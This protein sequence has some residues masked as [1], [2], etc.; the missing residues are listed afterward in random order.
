MSASRA[1]SEPPNQIR[2]IKPLPKI[3]L[4][5]P[6]PEGD[7]APPHDAGPLR[8]QSQPP[9]DGGSTQRGST[10]PAPA[11][12]R[13]TVPTFTQD[14]APP[15]SSSDRSMVAQTQRTFA[16]R[17]ST[18]TTPL[19]RTDSIHS[20]TEPAPSDLEVYTQAGLKWPPKGE[21]AKERDERTEANFL[22]V[23]ML[24]LAQQKAV[25]NLHAT[26]DANYAEILHRLEDMQHGGAVLGSDSGL[27]DIV[28]ENRGAIENLT[29][30]VN[31]LQDTQTEFY[32]FRRE[33]RNDIA[34]VRNSAKPLSALPSIRR[35]VEESPE[36]VQGSNKRARTEDESQADKDR[37]SDSRHAQTIQND[38]HFWPVDVK[39]AAEKNGPRR[40]A[41]RAL[42]LANIDLD[43]MYS[44]RGVSGVRDTISI[45]FRE[46]PQAEAFIRAVRQ[47]PEGMKGRNA[48]LA[49]ESATHAKGKAK[50]VEEFCLRI[51][52]WNIHGRLALKLTDEEIIEMIKANDIT[53]FQET[54]LRPGDENCVDLPRGYSIVSMAR[55][56]TADFQQAWGGLA[57]VIS[58]SV[59]YT[60]RH[61]LSAPDMIV[62]EFDALFLIG[63]YLPPPGSPWNQWAD[64]DPEQRLEQVVTLCSAT[65]K[66]VVVEGDLNGRVGDKTPAGAPLGRCSLDP[67]VN[68][69]GRWIL[70]LCKDCGLTIVNGTVK[71][72]AFPGAF[73]SFQPL[74]RTVID[75]ALV[76]NALVDFLPD[77]SL[78]VRDAADWSDHSQ[79]WFEVPVRGAKRY[80]VPKPKSIPIQL[81]PETDL[82][83]AAARLLTLS[84]SAE[85]A[86]RQLYG[87]VTTQ[88]DPI[89]VYVAAT[90][91][92]AGKPYSKAGFAL[93]WGPSNSANTMLR[94]DQGSESRGC[95]SCRAARNSAG[96]Q[97]L[98]AD[99]LHVVATRNPHLLL[100]GW[101]GEYA[102]TFER[103]SCPRRPTPPALDWNKAQL[104][105]HALAAQ[106]M[107]QEARWSLPQV[108]SVSFNADHAVA[109]T[110]A[111]PKVSTTIPEIN[112][113]KKRTPTE[114]SVDEVEDPGDS[115]RG[116]RREREMLR[117]NLVALLGCETGREFWDLIR[118]WTDERPSRP[119]VSLD[120]LHDSF[121]ARLNPP[122]VM[123][124]HFDAELHETLALMSATIPA[125]T[126]DSTPE[127]FFSRR[128]TDEDIVRLKKK[129][130]EK[131]TRSAHGIDLITYSRIMKIPNDALR[132]LI[133]TCVDLRS[134]PQQ[135]LV[136]ILIGVLKA[137]KAVDD[138]ESYRLIGLECCLLKC[139]TLLFDDRLREWGL[140]NK[141]VPP[142]QNGFQPKRRTDDNSFILRCAI[143]R[144]RAE[145]KTLYVF[146]AD[147]TN[148]FPTTDI[149]T[150]WNLLYTAGVGGP[151]FDWIRMVYARMS[152]IVRSDGAYSAA[153]RSLIGLLTGD[154]ASPG[155]WNVYAADLKLP[156][157]DS[158]IRLN[159]R[160][161]NQLEQADD[162]AMF[163][164][165][166]WTLQAKMDYFYNW[167]CRKFM[168][169]SPPKSEGMIFGPLPAVLPVFRVG[170][171]AVQIV[172]RHKYVGVWFTSTHHN[173]FAAHY[174]EKASKARRLAN[175]T[176]ARVKSHLG[177]L[178]MK[179]GLQLYMS[180]V[181][182]YLI[183]G[184]E[185]AL[186]VDSSLVDE[187]VEIQQS[188]LRR[189]LGLNSSSMLSVLYTE[190]GQVPI[191]I[192][193]LL[194]AL[195]RLRY[196]LTLPDSEDRIARDAL[197]DSLALFRARKASWIGDIALVL[198]RLPTPILVTA[199]DLSNDDSVKA[200]TERVLEVLDADLQ[201]DID[202]FERTHLLR[203]RVERISEGEDQFRLGLVTR[204]RRHY[205]DIVVPA[206]R[207][208]IT[209]LMLSDHNLSVERLRYP[210]RY[211]AAAP[212]D[213]RL[214]RFCRGAVEDEAHALLVCT[215]HPGLR[216]LRET[217][218][219]DVMVE[220]RGIEGR[221]SAD[222]PYDFLKLL[223]SSRKT[224]ARL[225]K[226]VADVMA[227]Y[228]SHPRYI[229]AVLYLP[230]LR[231]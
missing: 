11:T 148:A 47:E 156:V 26:I 185:I 7:D 104:N 113:Y 198:Q 230:P 192:R 65:S 191:K 53:I 18:S 105:P 96:A 208:A 72:E 165:E 216:L 90:C 35:R 32:S 122:A 3:K 188:Y 155:F 88:S 41:S 81:G 67:V 164:T 168:F 134:A 139:M 142:T 202:T 138:P 112:E 167:S 129:L 199:E 58:D 97:G 190:T 212:R 197:L 124:A 102:M 57:A 64:T 83:R 114:I 13:P 70:R 132:D 111:I 25:D 173:I 217:F 101:A 107:A 17:A 130:R 183:S 145:G 29:H 108:D 46:L 177:S 170:P 109:A 131:G 213:L 206:H 201:C 179:E 78:R 218:L 12:V 49:S 174:A 40:I 151:W 184:G 100:L 103:D 154:T 147:M 207:K 91:R 94:I 140:V 178:P 82:D 69:R 106:P 224:T 50:Q 169:I 48:K 159:G 158:D 21:R 187:M 119:Q 209:R 215:A 128:V 211:R 195:S 84:V 30:T 220:I 157:H 221:W 219:R 24:L 85:D 175:A 87:P 125:C 16:A 137:G 152:Y 123:P 1:N 39:K 74:G 146:F 193:R 42:E 120:Q 86:A 54:F 136:T 73:T 228:D 117:K 143:D 9:E 31:D 71:E 149:A 45:R 162:E 37:H 19:T 76:S 163:S 176:F 77:K 141:I 127:G 55:P 222:R 205:L 226:F 116:R 150:L 22:V 144:A 8:T 34:N 160:P 153:F 10:V 27:T 180:R 95:A 61:D 20:I 181:D 227:I 44:A 126:I 225:A 200:I 196:L 223:L 63:V 172:P 118:S 15:P 68:T 203:D 14:Q 43:H 36:R 66:Y 194:R 161:V 56:K 93:Y 23:G 75:F 28:L 182:C 166:A 5:G 214:C 59:E 62:I 52:A 99:Y 171:D 231:T 4:R 204:R 89:S 2:A 60:V 210:G 189:L 115:H 229:P 38:V 6:R 92:D 98:L 110:I 80:R 51:L 186:D 33:A 133:Q 135:W 79:L 121:K